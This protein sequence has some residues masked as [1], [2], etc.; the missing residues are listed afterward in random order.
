[1]IIVTFWTDYYPT[2]NARDMKIGKGSAFGMA[3]N[4]LKKTFEALK[5]MDLMDKMHFY[6]CNRWE[7]DSKNQWNF[8]NISVFHPQDLTYINK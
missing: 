7:R 3:K 2:N 1:M 8:W 6:F 4:D 5:L